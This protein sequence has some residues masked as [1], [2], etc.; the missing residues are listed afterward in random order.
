MPLGVVIPAPVQLAFRTSQNQPFL[1]H[2]ELNK[3]GFPPAFDV[4][5]DRRDADDHLSHSVL[6]LRDKELEALKRLASELLR[7]DEQELDEALSAGKL[8]EVES[9]E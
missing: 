1:R 5:E 9:D 6:Y 3:V 7:Y 2:P 4:N 8:Y